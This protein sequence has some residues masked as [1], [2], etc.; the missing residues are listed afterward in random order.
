M[1]NK[2][3]REMLLRGHTFS[4][5]EQDGFKILP[6]EIPKIKFNFGVEIEGYSKLNY[7]YFAKRFE[8]GGLP[9]ESY[10]WRSETTAPEKW[11]FTKDGSID[12][13]QELDR[14]YSI[15]INSPI[16]KRHKGVQELYT[17]CE[18]LGSY[19]IFKENMLNVNESCGLHVHFGN[20]C[21]SEKDIMNIIF[22]HSY[23]RID[24]EPYLDSSRIDNSYCKRIN[25]DDIED[26]QEK[27]YTGREKYNAVHC[28]ENTVEFRQHQSTTDFTEIYMWIQML[29]SIVLY[30]QTTDVL[31]LDNMEKIPYFKELISGEYGSNT[32][33]SHYN[34]VLLKKGRRR[35]IT[36]A[37][38]LFEQI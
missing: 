31:T 24:I 5:I 9:S 37:S 2:K 18:I 19:R 4:T 7:Y 23:Y 32:V 17:A 3:L 14:C 34:D 33:L 20:E 6:Q 36:P 1:E 22:L 8:K 26:L 27:I 13:P 21:L 16:L 35:I 28:T 11:G 30:A 38:Q 25:I 29:Q 12:P 15:E 10:D